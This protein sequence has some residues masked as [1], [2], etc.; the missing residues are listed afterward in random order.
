V[1]H[2]ENGAWECGCQE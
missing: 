2:R 1:R